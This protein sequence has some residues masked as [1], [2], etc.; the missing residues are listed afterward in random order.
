MSGWDKRCGGGRRNRSPSIDDTWFS[1]R[2]GGSAT[3][4]GFLEDRAASRAAAVIWRRRGQW[5]LVV[6]PALTE[7]ERAGVEAAVQAAEQHTSAGE[8]VPR[9]VGRSGFYR[10]AHHQPSAIECRAGIDGTCDDRN[11]LVALGMAALRMPCG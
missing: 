8:D 3:G 6:K 4:R 7:A 9:I 10:E 11:R 1:T 5:R 2:H